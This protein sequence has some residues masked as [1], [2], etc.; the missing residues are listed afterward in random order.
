VLF[1]LLWLLV[2]AALIRPAVAQL[3]RS[4]PATLAA[5]LTATALSAGL[6]T[7]SGPRTAGL[8]AT[9]LVAA[10]AEAPPADSTGPPQAP[11]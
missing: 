11:P 7:I 10:S 6:P 1:T 5:P 2:H 4:S 9:V 8:A 3:H